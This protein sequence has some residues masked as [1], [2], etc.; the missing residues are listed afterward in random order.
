MSF[1]DLDLKMTYRSSNDDIVKDFMIPVLK[2]SVI[3]KRAVGFFSS[4]SLIEVTKGL[5]GLVKNNG[6]IYIVASPVLSEEDIN[7]IKKGYEKRL[8]IEQCL[9]KALEDPKDYFE[10]ERLNLLAHLIA[11]GFLDIK[12]AFLEGENEIGVYHEKI[13]LMVDKEGNKIAFTG[14]L[15]ETRTAFLTNFESIDVFMSWMGEDSKKRVEEK[16]RNFDDLWND[17][18]YKVKV[19]EFPKVAYDKLKKYMKKDVDL[20]IDN[21]Q[22]LVYNIKSKEEFFR[23]PKD[24]FFRE[25]QAIAI[26]NWLKNGGRGIFNMATGTGKTITALGAASQLVKKLDNN[27]AIVIVC[28]YQ[29][30]VEQWAEEV[31]KWNVT[32]IVGYSSSSDKNWYNKLKFRIDGYNL[33]VVKNLCFITTNATF[34]QKKIQEQ[35]RKIKKNSLIIVDEVHHMG[36]QN[37]STK[38]LDN[39]VYRLGLSATLERHF[40]PQGTEKIYDYF[41][42]ECINYSIERAIE[43]KMLTPYYY[44]PVVGYLSFDELIEYKR[45][46][47]QLLKYLEIKKDGNKK[48]VKFSEKAKKIAIERS[49]I[50]AGASCKLDLLREYIKPYKD[51]SQILVYCGASKVFLEDTYDDD[52]T[53]FGIRQID[54]VT[55]ILGNELGMRVSQYTSRE[56]IQEREIIKSE[57]EKGENLQAIVAIKCL[58]EGLNIPAIKT[59]FILASTTNPMEYIQRRG[60]ILR[61]YKGKE[62]AEI[63]DF[64]VLPRPLDEVKNLAEDE[65]KVDLPLIKKEIARIEEFCRIAINSSEG[66]ELIRKIK[67]AYDL[68]DAGGVFTVDYEF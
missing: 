12:I 41:G 3:Y 43:E 13:G 46:S 56:T 11:K 44:Y 9:L 19:I 20:E 54:V 50:I 24:V 57:F 26:E 6:K 33:G 40:D 49:K 31:E 4:S 64:V 66:Y 62:Y 34:S 35:L 32:P 17:R 1:T 53:S 59:A 36:A 21:K 47:R 45:L 7:A 14:S 37:L 25:Y 27:I 48:I 65:I 63:Y 38:L 58:D 39:F 29:H 68:Y 42:E 51:K 52:L 60:R 30:L 18:T 10:E 55:Q 61:L 22:F 2:E 67:E 8:I 23:K 28:P 16:E 15:N 5:C